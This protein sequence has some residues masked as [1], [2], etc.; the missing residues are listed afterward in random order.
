[1]S[2]KSA[3][4]YSVISPLISFYGKITS[5]FIFSP[6]TTAKNLRS[7]KL[8]FFLVENL[9]KNLKAKVLV[10]YKIHEDNSLLTMHHLQAKVMTMHHHHPSCL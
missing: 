1:M 8:W 7:T 5:H 3:K 2:T 9:G 6:S 10:G 4:K